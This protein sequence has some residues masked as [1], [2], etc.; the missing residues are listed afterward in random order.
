M[1]Y[2]NAP[3][4][5]PQ[6]VARIIRKPEEINPKAG[7]ANLPGLAIFFMISDPAVRIQEKQAT[8][9]APVMSSARSDR[10]MIAKE[11]VSS[12]ISF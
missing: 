8:S 9:P 1:G 12:E 6:T 2:F 5:A 10:V 7:R 3:A 4:A 11:R